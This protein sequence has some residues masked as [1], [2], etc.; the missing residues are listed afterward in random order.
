[1]EISDGGEISVERLQSTFHSSEVAL[2]FERLVRSH[3]EM[4]LHKKIKN[5]TNV[6]RHSQLGH[7]PRNRPYEF[8]CSTTELQENRESLGH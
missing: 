1:M 7:L 4:L 3:T 5:R 6:R 8:G 2:A